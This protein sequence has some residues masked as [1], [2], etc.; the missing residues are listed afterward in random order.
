MQSKN[1]GDGSFHFDGF[2]VQHSWAVTPLPYRIE[3]GLHQERMAAYYVERS[4]APVTAD[5]RVQTH[6]AFRFRLSSEGRILR[7][8]ARDQLRFEYAFAEFHGMF[9]WLRRLCNVRR[10]HE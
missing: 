4:D 3:S 6:S 8:D 7:F 5:D 9:F 2:A 10:F 1:Y